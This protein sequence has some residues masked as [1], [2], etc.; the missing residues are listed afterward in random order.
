MSRLFS[1]RSSAARPSPEPASSRSLVLARRMARGAGED[2]AGMQ[3]MLSTAGVHHFLGTRAG[4]GLALGLAVSLFIFCVGN[5]FSGLERGAL[6]AMFQ[7]RGRLYPSQKVVIVQADE[8]TVAHWKRWPLPREV[9]AEIVRNLKH[10]GA[11]TIAFDVQFPV[12]SDR[13]ADDADLIK[14]CR[15]AGNVIQASNFHIPGVHTS[16]S[17]ASPEGRVPPLA[18][19]FRLTDHSHFGFSATGRETAIPALLDTAPFMGHVLVFPEL[20]D[21][22]LLRIPHFVRFTNGAYPSLALAAAVHYLGLKPKDVTVTDDAVEVAGRRIPINAQGEALVNW[23]GPPGTIPTYTFQEVLAAR[24]EERLPPGTF[25]DCVVLIGIT[26]AGAFERYATPFSSV[27]PAVELQASA[28]DNILENRPLREA[29]ALWNFALLLATAL[30][31]GVLTAQRDARASA[32][33]TLVLCVGLWIAGFLFLWHAMLYLK[34]AAPI[35][36]VLLTCAAT[37]SY[38]QLRDAHELKIAEERYALASRGA[39]DGI[40]DWNLQSGEIYFSPRWKTMIGLADTA[41]EST[42]SEWLRRVHSDDDAKLQA[43]LTRHLDGHSA[44]FENEHRLLHED[45]IYRWVLARGIR[46]LGEHGQPSRIAGSL[47]DITERK[48]AEEQL[49]RNAFYD[50]LTNLPNRAL[51]MDRLGRAIGRAR[52]HPDYL[53]AV[54]FLDVDRFKVVNDSLGHVV[55]DE[56]LMAVAKRLEKCLRPGDTAARLGGDEF[57]LLLDD[58]HDIEDATRVAERVHIEL[59]KPFTLGGA[60]LF[61]AASIGI[62]ISGDKG[63]LT[64]Y[65]RPEDLLRDA[66]TA[67][68]RAKALGRGRHEIFDEAM[69]E[70]A[71]ATLRLETDLRRALENQSFHVFYQPIVSLGDGRITGFEAL[72]RWEHPERGMVPPSEFIPLAEETGLVIALDHQILRQACRQARIWQQQFPREAHAWNDSASDGA[73]DA[74]LL[75]E[76]VFDGAVPAASDSEASTLLTLSAN[77]SSKHFSQPDLPAQI[78]QILKETAFPPAQLRLEITESVILD[79]IESAAAILQQLKG[80]GVQLALD[81]FGTGYSSLSYLHRLPLDILKID[82]SFVMRLGGGK[83]GL[84]DNSEIVSA[85]IM[86]A[87]NLNMA[88]VAEGVETRAQM[89]KLQS[90]R[91]EYGQG[92][93]FSRP[94]SSEEAATLLMED[95]AWSILSD[96]TGETI[97][98]KLETGN[99]ASGTYARLH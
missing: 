17:S 61:P 74:R 23:V 69:H 32:I 29:P 15:E 70:R 12:A 30:V 7:M 67:M 6:D 33:W 25:R 48:V 46:V 2:Q 49:L 64:R 55:G 50:G 58:V 83:S 28:L 24:P 5:W 53:F 75:E 98:G 65:E 54:L 84:D 18:E 89:E 92:F 22:G 63:V 90:L 38:R 34:I 71:V 79:N 68:Y 57:T 56:L 99:A 45:G 10:D 36:G 44:H 95:R 31:A 78:E 14:A 62:A 8:A 3:R 39:N 51:F 96:K 82:R 35:M 88:I 91:C 52:R 40:W 60:E 42:P 26:H 80:L 93:Y 66:D 4:Q 1:R 59:S 9:Y 81:D 16:A 87:R 94:L 19:R 20:S 37:L 27:Q 73:T 47:T 86:L 21:G 13:P 43:D 97:K 76:I 11:K 41:H 85:I 77:L 72:A